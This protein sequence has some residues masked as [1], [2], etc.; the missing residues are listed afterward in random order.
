MSPGLATAGADVRGRL[1]G[2]EFS[3]HGASNSEP[4]HEHH[5]KA[6]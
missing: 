1:R 4:Q 2:H 6:R 3:G 5:L